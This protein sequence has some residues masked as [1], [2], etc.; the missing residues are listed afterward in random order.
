M[1]DMAAP[2]ECPTVATVL[3]PWADN[4][5]CTAARTSAAVLRNFKVRAVNKAICGDFLLGLFI[6]KAAVDLDTAVDP[7]E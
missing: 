6:S 7:G 5:L 3:I 2:R 4:P 1:R